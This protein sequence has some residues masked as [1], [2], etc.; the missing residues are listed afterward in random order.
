[1]TMA[2]SKS[3]LTEQELT[4]GIIDKILGA[5]MKGRLKKIEPILKNASPE[6]VR[7]AKKADKSNQ[8]FRK[9]AE[10]AFKSRTGKKRQSTADLRKQG[11]F[12]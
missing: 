12:V 1:M 10:K 2:S 7:L 11:K 9:A 3:K 8:E 5:M 4:E 6:L